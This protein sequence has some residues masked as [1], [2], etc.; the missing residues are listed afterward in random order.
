[1][2][3]LAKLHDTF[4][5]LSGQPSL[6]RRVRS[7]SRWL[8]RAWGCF[9]GILFVQVVL[10]ACGSDQ[11]SDESR[12]TQLGST[13][14]PCTTYNPGQITEAL[15]GMPPGFIDEQSFRVGRVDRVKNHL[16]G[17]PRPYI[18]VLFRARSTNNFRI[19]ERNLQ[20]S[21][22]GL[23]TL[24]GPNLDPIALDIAPAQGAVDSAFKHEV[25]HAL[26]SHIMRQNAGM[27][28]RFSSAFGSE[29]N[30]RNIGAYARTNARE[31]FAEAFASFY[32]S[33]DAQ[34]F[35]SA[36]APQTFQILKSSLL[37]ASFD[38]PA[39][40]SQVADVWMQLVDVSDKTYVEISLPGSGGKVALCKGTKSEC[41][42]NSAAVFASF[43]P[44]PTKIQG[45]TIVRSEQPI[46][47]S[48]GLQVTVLTYDGANK[49]QPLK[50]VK[51]VKDG[52]P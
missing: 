24:M 8:G 23:T 48:E 18:E 25:G 36:H 6:G 7:W 3:A 43:G 21:V 30:N 52:G 12:T 47:I 35:I 44:S 39:S 22:M 27:N 46:T 19:R 14:F 5:G 2:L 51:F 28:S 10:S 15:K 26:E 13:V 38:S 11:E 17:I 16:T 34:A 45:R 41:G 49:V 9:V 29:R 31:Y 4:R 40:T 20:P 1:M 33:K 42:T 32:C 50:T 37:P